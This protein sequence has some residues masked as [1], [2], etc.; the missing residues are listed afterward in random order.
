M[1]RKANKNWSMNKV[2][3]F[4]FLDYWTFKKFTMTWQA[5][6][7]RL[8]NQQNIKTIYFELKQREYK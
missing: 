8:R 2:A 4:V 6:A 3:N 1:A 7:A 5:K